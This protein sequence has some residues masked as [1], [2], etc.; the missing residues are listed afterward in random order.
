MEILLASPPGLFGDA[1]AALI[2]KLE[3]HCKVHRFADASAAAAESA[4][5]AIPELNLALLDIDGLDAPSVLTAFAARYPGK[6]VVALGTPVDDAFIDTLFDAGATGYLPKSYS[7][8]VITGVLKLVLVGAP[9]RPYLP[10]QAEPPASVPGTPEPVPAPAPL[11][12]ADNRREFG[13]SERQMEV[14]TQAAQ[15]KSNQAIAK[16]LGIT[17]GTVKLHMTAVLRA[18]NVESRSEAILIATRM[19]SVSFRQIQEAASGKLDL[20]WLLPHMAH[21]RL[22]KST[23]LFR[24][25]QP[26][27]RLY[28]LQRGTVRLQEI[29]TDLEAGALFGEIG[30][31]APRHERTCT[32]LCATDVDL[33]TLSEA[34]VKRLYFLNPR[35]AIYVV[36]L[37]ATHFSADR[38]RSV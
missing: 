13:L 3:P 16:Q 11:P 31:F 38:E 23:V 21:Q 17:E 28:Y 27:E 5:A 36:Q 18:L 15:G 6:P 34:Q 14:L 1:L 37:L 24:K 26:G 2:G 32:A 4:Q 20:D 9:Y 12:E 10:R 35:F 7:E 30:I 19:N 22:P 25:G 29:E 33:F 8:A